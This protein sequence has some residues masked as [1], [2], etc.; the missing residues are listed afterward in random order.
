MGNVIADIRV[1]PALPAESQPPPPILEEQV[2]EAWIGA[3]SRSPTPPPPPPPAT[4]G[5]QRPHTLD[6]GSLFKLTP[7]LLPLCSLRVPLRSHTGVAE[8]AESVKQPLS[9]SVASPMLAG[10]G[11]SPASSPAEAARANLLSEFRT[12]LQP[13]PDRPT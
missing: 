11:R 1:T 13:P 7:T 9:V 6:L 2:A 3:E 4:Q 12:V 8:G 5:S 10:G